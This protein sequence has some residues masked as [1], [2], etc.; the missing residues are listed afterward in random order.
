MRQ[1]APKTSIGLDQNIAG[2]LCYL[3]GWVT[4]LVFYLIE[5]DNSF[6]RYH[7]MQ[8]I[9]FGAACNVP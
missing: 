4:G 2:A 7:A 9:W 8:S 5:K 1:E 3:F 6:V